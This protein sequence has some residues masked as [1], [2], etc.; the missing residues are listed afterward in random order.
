MV[1]LAPKDQLQVCFPKLKCDLTWGCYLLGSLP[2]HYPGRTISQPYL[3]SGASYPLPLLCPHHPTPPLAQEALQ[4]GVGSCPPPPLNPISIVLTGVASWD[5]THSLPYLLFPCS[6]HWPSAHRHLHTRVAAQPTHP[7]LGYLLTS[8][9]PTKASTI[10]S[11]L[12]PAT[13]S[14]P[15]QP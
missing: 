12:H 10:S 8:L 9:T 1:A 15:T 5:G 14:R 6:L 7:Q 4:M 11:E 2:T 3:L 13:R